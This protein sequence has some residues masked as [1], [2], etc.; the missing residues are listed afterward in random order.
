MGGMEL[1]VSDREINRAVIMQK[2]AKPSR[3]HIMLIVLSIKQANTTSG[4]IRKTMI[5]GDKEY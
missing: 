3:H 4:M 5:T 2:S 1:K